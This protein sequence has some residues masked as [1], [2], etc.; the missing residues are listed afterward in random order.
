MAEEKAKF[1]QAEY[2]KEYRRQ[3]VT[4]VSV[5]L[6]KKHDQDIIEHLETV[7]SKSEYIKGLIRDD[8]DSHKE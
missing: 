4:R 8:I 5:I 7:P 6:N 1:D 2:I 3:Y